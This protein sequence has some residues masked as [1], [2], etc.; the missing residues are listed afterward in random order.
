[1]IVSFF[2]VTVPAERAQAFEA[3]W[4]QRAGMVDK[5]PGF[6]GMDV[7]RDGDK[8]GHYVVMTR[9][10]ERANFDNWANSPE[11]TAGHRHTNS[12]D[13]NGAAPQGIEFFEVV[14]STPTGNASS[15]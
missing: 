2:H 6:Q 11:F 14:P 9:W 3:S 15:N 13:G 1:M 4:S 10:A 12:G 5:M 7:L 8:P